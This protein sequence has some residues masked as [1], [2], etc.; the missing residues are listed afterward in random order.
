MTK[1]KLMEMN[2]TQEELKQIDASLPSETWVEL[3][4]KGEDTFYY[5]MNYNH[6]VFGTLEKMEEK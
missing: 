2:Y 4:K 5:V 1:Q 6:N 3:R